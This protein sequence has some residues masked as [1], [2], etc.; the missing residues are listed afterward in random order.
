MMAAPWP[1]PNASIMSPPIHTE[2]SWVTSS[3][4][5]GSVSERAHG[6]HPTENRTP[7]SIPARSGDLRLRAWRRP[8]A[9]SGCLELHT[10]H[11]P[12][13]HLGR[14]SPCLTHVPMGNIMFNPSTTSISPGCQV[15]SGRHLHEVAHIGYEEPENEE[16]RSRADREGYAYPQSNTRAEARPESVP[17]LRMDAAPTNDITAMRRASEHGENEVTI[18]SRNIPPTVAPSHAA[19]SSWSV[20]QVAGE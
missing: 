14:D 9:C 7:S 15:E 13:W 19:P 17:L 2:M 8:R 4:I 11:L 16:D 20:T 10:L 12:G 18:P 6:A 1:K 5:T 3:I